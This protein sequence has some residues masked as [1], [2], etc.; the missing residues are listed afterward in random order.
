MQSITRQRRKT[1]LRGKSTTTRIE[2][3]KS[4]NHSYL[5][6]FSL[7]GKS[8]TTR[9]ET[10][11]SGSGSLAIFTSLR[12]KSTTTRIE[13]ELIPFM[14]APPTVLEENPPQQ[15]LKLGVNTINIPAP[16]ES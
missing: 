4:V 1:S 10:C 15:G 7:R 13:T 12:G 3:N 14:V 8:T 5:D 2:T 16:I 9:I 11:P 6:G